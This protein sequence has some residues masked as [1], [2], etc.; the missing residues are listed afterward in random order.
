LCQLVRVVRERIVI[1]T[2]D[3]TTLARLWIIDDYLPELL[4]EHAARFPPIEWLC[5]RLPDAS[6]EPLP[7]P[8]DCTDRFLSALWARPHDLLDPATRAATSPWYDLPAATVEL[9][10]TR[11]RRDLEDGTWQRRYGHL[12][13]LN[14]LDVG[15][16]LI[17]SRITT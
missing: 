9:A 1:V 7:V 14:E 12:L 11:L 17:T 4:G 6:A 16:R 2:M 8:R 10:L 3:V 13:E 15:L 5:E